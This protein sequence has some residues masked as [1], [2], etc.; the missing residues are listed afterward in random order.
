MMRS[1]TSSGTARLAGEQTYDHTPGKSS[2]SLI[3]TALDPPR[4]PTRTAFSSESAAPLLPRV[5]LDSLPLEVLER[6]G[7][8]C[9]PEIA[10]TTSDGTRTTSKEWTQ[11]ATDIV[12]FSSTC[13]TAWLASRPLVYR[14]YG[15]DVRVHAEENAES[16]AAHAIH[17]LSAISGDDE[18]DS[19]DLL[20]PPPCSIRARSV[21]HLSVAWASPAFFQQNAPAI[22][23]STFRCPT[24]GKVFVETLARLSMLESLALVWRDEECVT[25]NSPYS[26]GT[27]P[28]DILLAIAAHPTLRDLYLCGIKFSRYFSAYVAPPGVPLSGDL[29]PFLTPAIRSLTFNACHDSV[30]EL[31]TLAPAAT[32]IRVH[33]DFAADPG[34]VPDCWWDSEVWTRAEE[35]EL[36]LRWVDFP[37]F[38]PLRVLRLYEPFPLPLLR[39]HIFPLLRGLHNLKH[40]V[41]FVWNSRE[42]AAGF[43]R[44]VRDVAHE[45]EELGIGVDSEELAWWQGP[46]SSYGAELSQFRKLRSF[47][48]DYS[49]YAELDHPAVRTHIFPL[50]SR[51]VLP[52][53]AKTRSPLERIRWFGSDVYLRRFPVEGDEGAFDWAWSDD[54]RF[55]IS[56]PHWA[57]Q[58]GS[59][60]SPSTSRNTGAATPSSASTESTASSTSS[61]SAS[62]ASAS[63]HGAVQERRRKRRRSSGAA[64]TS[65]FAALVAAQREADG[66]QHEADGVERGVGDCEM[67][68]EMLPEVES[69]W[70]EDDSGFYDV[71]A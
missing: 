56:L 26:L 20:W 50:L 34:I 62:R 4:P 28:V 16:V 36:F 1:S 67:G 24:F 43:L 58:A 29:I 47:T 37:P 10:P 64:P 46:L 69:E 52:L 15:V 27:V 19:S 23:L 60:T 7:S 68:L 13:R 59:A 25:T 54:P 9:V 55:A 17:R 61:D 14:N 2:S 65:I 3:E 35:L 70:V 66:L 40:L 39:S 11:R 41:L 48:W 32:E 18:A 44:E 38:V 53:L 42:L 71:T 57:C 51:Q 12:N 33:R 49:P 6:I 63:H 22:G 8:F 31:V 5:S 30:L 45:V 21:R